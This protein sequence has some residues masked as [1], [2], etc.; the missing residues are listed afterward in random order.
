MP[1]FVFRK[2]R[3]RSCDTGIQHTVYAGLPQNLHPFPPTLTELM[4][5]H[6]FASSA[7]TIR[8]DKRVWE[9]PAR[10]KGG[11]VRGKSGGRQFLQSD[12]FFL[13]APRHEHMHFPHLNFASA[14]SAWSHPLPSPASVTTSF[15]SFFPVKSMLK[16]L[17]FVSRVIFPLS[18][19]FSPSSQTW[20]TTE[21]DPPTS[22]HR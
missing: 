3:C 20:K 19:A 12:R 2:R 22:C 14:Q 7:R 6:R 18:N 10:Q 9:K 15:I 5:R 8:F 21:P 4:S 13:P 11:E 16:N 17:A 1:F